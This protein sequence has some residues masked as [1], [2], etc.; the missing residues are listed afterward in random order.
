LIAN[1]NSNLSLELLPA[2]DIAGG[3]SVR[4]SQG[5][6]SSAIDFGSPLE[7][8]QQFISAGAKWI[9]LVDLDAAFSRPNNQSLIAEV[10]AQLSGVKIELSGGIGGQEALETAVSLGVERIV[11]STKALDDESFVKA[12]IAKHGSLI[13]A[14]IDVRGT[15]LEARGQSGHV[16]PELDDALAMLGAFGCS[17]YVVTDIM[18]DGMLSGPNLE[19]L[20]YVIAKTGKPVVASG[21]ISTLDDIR[22]LKRL[23]GRGLEGAIL[24]KALYANK[25]S[26]E[27]ALEVA[28]EHDI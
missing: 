3:K 2:I 8:A 17:R 7:V 10:V 19:L 16:G 4:L 11:L 22:S 9:H 26:F 28:E 25:F 21:G 6:S 23:V 5:D 15:R 18:R 13:A 14:G 27:Q 12:A 24:G 1:K 20:D